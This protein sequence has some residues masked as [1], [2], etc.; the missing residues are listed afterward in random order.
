MRI[1]QALVAFC[2]AIAMV[3]AGPSYASA[4]DSPYQRGPDPTEASVKAIAGPFAVDQVKATGHTGFGSGT[5]FYPKDE[6]GTFG[7]IAVSPGFISPEGLVHW[8]AKT[9]ASHGFVV[10]AMGTF[11]VA[12]PPPSRGDQLRAALDYMKTKSPVKD[13]V[14]PT[15]LG[16]S[17]HSMGGGG[18]LDAA[19][20]MPDLKAAVPLAPWY[21][22]GGPVIPK[23]KAP[24]LVVGA[25][26][27]F[28]APMAIFAT[29]FYKAL[30]SPNKALLTLPG[31]HMTPFLLAN[32]T[33]TKFA[34]S[35]FK[36]FLDDDTRYDQ[37]LCPNPASYEGTCPLT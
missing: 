16:L 31:D 35:W 26:I 28:V 8:Y 22:T 15:R 36:R 18:T 12:D 6:K 37:F 21:L 4:L 29:P 30:T 7:T 32:P 13:K 23:V 3:V 1:R 24:T 2:A 17:G 20:K 9:L 5:I 34:V 14:D 11:T 10:M 33:L 25:N 19:S 27:D